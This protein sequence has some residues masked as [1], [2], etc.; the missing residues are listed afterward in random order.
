M[1]AKT[2]LLQA[3]IMSGRKAIILKSLVKFYYQKIKT[4]KWTLFAPITS[5]IICQTII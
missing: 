2:S 3:L 5:F 4:L 1:L